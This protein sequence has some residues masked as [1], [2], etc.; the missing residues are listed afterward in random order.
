VKFRRRSAA[1]L[2]GNRPIATARDGMGHAQQRQER[3]GCEAA[4]LRGKGHCVM[5]STHGGACH[6]HMHTLPARRIQLSCHPHSPAQA[7]GASAPGKLGPQG[8][9]HGAQGL[10]A[11][12]GGAI[13]GHDLSPPGPRPALVRARHWSVPLVAWPPRHT[14][15]VHWTRPDKISGG[16]T[17]CT[18]RL[19]R[20][21]PPG[22]FG[23]ASKGQTC[24]AAGR[25]E[26]PCCAPMR[27]RS[28]AN[29]LPCE[30]KGLKS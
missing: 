26:D 22:I 6:A 2:T 4:P 20:S 24:P 13:T 19:R 18:F 25:L 15:L 3:Q 1:Q 7:S 10:G 8:L 12:A 17:A 16:P 29:A 14:A 28:R 30:C 27:V 5:C 9:A 23:T 21:R 11:E